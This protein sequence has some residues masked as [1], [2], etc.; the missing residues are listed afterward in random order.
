MSLILEKLSRR[1]TMLYYVI[2]H[3][4]CIS[5][6]LGFCDP[7]HLD[8]AATVRHLKTSGMKEFLDDV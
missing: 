3:F 1:F 5:L 8:I 2:L 6:R 4:A 7:Y